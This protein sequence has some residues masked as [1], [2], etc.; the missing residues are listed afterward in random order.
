MIDKRM[1]AMLTS[2][3][4]SAAKNGNVNES[5]RKLFLDTQEKFENIIDTLQ[6]ALNIISSR[7][8][9]NDL[10]MG[11]FM[12][13][14]SDFVGNFFSELK[15]LKNRCEDEIS[16]QKRYIVLLDRDLEKISS[17]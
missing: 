7:K 5:Q 3:Y 10:T 4:M 17:K 16:I 12:S 8:N 1:E 14:H 2:E 15:S 11:E 6:N 13:A 9:I